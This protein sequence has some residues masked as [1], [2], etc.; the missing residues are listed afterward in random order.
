[1]GEA[2]GDTSSII[3]SIT[4][5]AAMAKLMSSFGKYVQNFV[6]CWMILLF[7][8]FKNKGMSQVLADAIVDGLKDTPAIYALF[9]PFIGMLGSALTGSTTTVFNFLNIFSLLNHH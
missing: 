2:A 1:M 6:L 4:S 7:F 3:I 8:F 5:F 9:I